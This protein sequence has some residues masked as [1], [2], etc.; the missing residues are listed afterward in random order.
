VFSGGVRL[1]NRPQ[2]VLACGPGSHQAGE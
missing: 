2:I 1:K